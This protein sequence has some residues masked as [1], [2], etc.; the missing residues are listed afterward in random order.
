MDIK[1][2]LY[3]FT[4]NRSTEAV[5]RQARQDFLP[6]FDITAEDS[7][8]FLQVRR[9]HIWKDSLCA[10]KQRGFTPRKWLKIKFVGESAIDEGGPE[11]N[12]FALGCR[13]CS[14]IMPSSEVH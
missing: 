3:V 9:K 1:S 5:I 11:G 7:I 8:T 4:Y 14:E 10:F 2:A 12:T 6:E 13:S